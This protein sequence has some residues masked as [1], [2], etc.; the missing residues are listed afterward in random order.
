MKKKF[1]LSIVGGMLLGLSWPT[2]GFTPLIFVGFVPLFYLLHKNADEKS[3]RIFGY[4]Y[5]YFLIW[6]SISTW[7]LWNSTAFGMLFAILVNSLLMSLVILIYRW[8]SKKLPQ[9]TSTLFLIFLWISFEYMHLH[10]D[11]SWPWLN[12]GN[13]FSEK[14][15]WIQWYEYTGTFGGTL[16]IWW[17]N[18]LV[19]NALMADRG[20]R[21]KKIA[22]AILLIVVPIIVSMIIF[23]QFKAEQNKP[24][25]VVVLQPNIDPY[26][27]KYDQSND[28]NL[29]DLKDLLNQS[30]EKKP[31][32]VVAPETFFAEG[33][34]VYL[35]NVDQSSFYNKLISHL[36]QDIQLLSGIQFY[37]TYS[38][39]FTPTANYVEPQL[40]ADFY[41]S[42][43]L[44]D[45]TTIQIYHKSK[46]VVGVEHLPYRQFIEPIFGNIMLDLGG[47]VMSRAT[48]SQ[49]TAFKLYGGGKVAPI[50]CYESVYGE[51]VTGYIR[52]GANFL[53]I[54]TNDAWWG[55]TQGHQQHL[56][57]ARLRAIET[58]RPIARSAN[59]GISA[60]INPLGQIEKQLNYNLKGSLSH[61][62]IPQ[63]RYTFYVIY[64]DLIARLS[65]FLAGFTLLFA[66]ARKKY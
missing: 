7:W 6:N 26:T 40:W 29:K 45:S 16:W 34:G 46:L 39:K 1:I 22:R 56:S 5:L 65:L 20:I 25:Q 19:F 37:Q 9:R 42:A 13:V 8:V 36:D 24:V 21:S 60:F 53:A 52:E 18:I 51:F 28:Q 3:M 14:I 54:L 35:P 32:L 33:A 61:E 10:W 11:F 58:R 55:E 64:G 41:N 66:I 12:L 49:R 62:I 17:V 15:S 50:I 30:D 63:K 48:Q 38:N 47:T 43:F 2:Y 23:S 59:T 27:E 4:I 31:N 57:Y 44:S